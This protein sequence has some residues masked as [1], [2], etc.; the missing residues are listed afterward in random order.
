MAQQKG[1]ANQRK[2]TPAQIEK[3]RRALE[4]RKAGCGYDEI[5]AALGYANA[6]GA[7]KI[8][9]QAL[10]D[11]YR[12]PAEEIRTLEL[13]RVDRLLR[14]VWPR[15]LKGDVE[16]VDRVLKIMTRRARLLGLDRGV[17]PVVAEG[18]EVASGNGDGHGSFVAELERRLAGLVGPGDQESAPGGHNGDGGV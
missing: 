8:V 7:Y 6:G 1:K 14:A 9:Q 18:N 12:E 10:K 4:L 11:T 17:M 2:N 16:A 13:E 15:A 5:A 3:K